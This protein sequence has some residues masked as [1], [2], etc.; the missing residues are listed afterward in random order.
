MWLK[1]NRV[2]EP[3][4]GARRTTGRVATKLIAGPDVLDRRPSKKERRRT[5]KPHRSY[6]AARIFAEAATAGVVDPAAAAPPDSV[7]EP[8]G[9]SG[10]VAV[11]VGNE[12]T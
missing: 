3:G 2:S 8:A 5:N 1:I 4:S 7:T 6:D 11:V 10:P 9:G 12:M